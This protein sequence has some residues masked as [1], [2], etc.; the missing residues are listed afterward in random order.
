[1]NKDFLQIT[2]FTRDEIIHF[3]EKTKWIKAKFKSRE[4]Y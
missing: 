4:A 3:L 1:M 2:D